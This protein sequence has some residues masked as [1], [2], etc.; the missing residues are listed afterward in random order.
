MDGWRE[1]RA[2]WWHNFLGHF[3]GYCLVWPVS[4]R[5]GRWLHDRTIPEGER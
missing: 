2:F 4:P 5:A 3:V 1:W